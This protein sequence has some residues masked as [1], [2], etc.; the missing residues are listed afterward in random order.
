MNSENSKWHILCEK[1]VG[2]FSLIQQVIGHIPLALMNNRIPVA[3]YRDQCCYWTSQ[4]YMNADNVWEYYFEPIIAD[5]PASSLN[6][7]ILDHI[8]S[9][10]PHFEYPG[11]LINNDVFVTNNFGNH[12]AFKGQTLKIPHQWDDPDR[13]L[14]NRAAKIIADYVRPRQYIKE[15]V[16]LFF[17][18]QMKG[19]KVIGVHMRAT[20]V[21][22]VDEHNIHRRRSYSFQS[23]VEQIRRHLEEW[24]KARIFVGTDSQKALNGLIEIFGERVIHSSSIF[25]TSQDLAGTGPAGWVIPGYLAEDSQKAAKNGEEAIIDYLLLSRC[26]H[27]IHNGS[28]LARTALLKNPKLPHTNIHSKAAYFR[29]LIHLGNGEL[30]KFLKFSYQHAVHELK[31]PVKRLIKW[32]QP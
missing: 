2:L 24:P 21:T 7:E 4:G 12:K 18:E 32:D 23:F 15:K 17:E 29:S 26:Q 10:P 22:D 6:N 25:H 16:D 20:D 11:Y 31:K 9:R 8:K 13:Q 27:L 30:F 5:K 3:L 1:D 19:Y 14:R 28:G